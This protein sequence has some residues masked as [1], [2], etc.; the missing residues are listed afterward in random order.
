MQ[1]WIGW[2]REELRSEPGVQM[3][4]DGQL[5]EA[6]RS[7]SQ[8]LDRQDADVSARAGAGAALLRVYLLLGREQ[9]AQELQAQLSLLH[10]RGQRKQ[11]RWLIALDAAAVH[12]HRRQSGRVIELLMPFL[13]GDSPQ[14]CRDEALLMLAFAY[15]D[16]G[17]LDIACTLLS[18]CRIGGSDPDRS[19]ALLQFFECALMFDGGRLAAS[20]PALTFP[21]ARRLPTLLHP[22]LALWQAVS[23]AAQRPALLQ[24]ALWTFLASCQ[25]SRA[26]VWAD[27]ARV[28][29]GMQLL[30]CREPELADRVLG[31]LEQAMRA[32]SG[33]R[34]ALNLMWCKALWLSAHN[35]HAEAAVAYQ[36]YAQ[37]M[38]WRLRREYRHVPRLPGSY[39]RDAGIDSA[40]C[41]S[42]PPRYRRVLSYVSARLGDAQLSVAEMA[43]HINVTERA[44]QQTFRRCLGMSPSEL[45]RH[46]RVNGVA[47]SLNGAMP[48]DRT[49]DVASH[50]GLGNRDRL[51]T[52][53]R[54]ALGADLPQVVE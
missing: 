19:Q 46:L 8:A 40:F 42:L 17:D 30:T 43:A 13:V 22:V 3:A 20:C 44:L 31:P 2:L 1:G 35:R 27:E 7:L 26:E 15:A 41:A 11:A 34:L 18:R 9:D 32:S 4:L 28:L 48:G 51:R 23:P 49:R 47:D 53:A 45:L 16:L 14:S 52:S 6:A 37:E 10:V 38:E 36:Q 29:V 54:K 12:Q 25:R 50:W 5:A 24:S 39:T 21:E 33:H